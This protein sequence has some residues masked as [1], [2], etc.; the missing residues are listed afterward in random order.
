V[1]L[2]PDPNLVARKIAVSRAVLCAAPSYLAQH[3]TPRRI[4]DLRKHR[5]ILFP[6]VAPKGVWTFRRDGEK[7]T[8]SVPAAL[9][10]DDMD[11]VRS[12]V[13]A[14][15]GLGLL[16][17]YLAG[18]DLQQGNLVPLL[19]KFQTGAAAGIWLVYLPNRTLSSRM[20]VLIDFLVAR[21]GPTPS[22]ETGW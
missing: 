21:F 15:M 17:S 11:A 22:W 4:D 5:S 2:H 3:G 14:G 10:T 13:I 6:P 1:S 16:P 12:A 20:R 9:E 7:F 8:V 19:R 18:A